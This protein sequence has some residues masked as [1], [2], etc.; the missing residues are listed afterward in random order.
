MRKHKHKRSVIG[1][2]VL[3]AVGSGLLFAGASTQAQERIE[4]T[5]SAIKR[6]DAEAALPV[7][8]ITKEEIVRSGATTT[9]DLL[10]RLPAIQNG[11]GESS[12]V[13]GG[14][15]FNGVS[16]HSIGDTRTL[17]LLN[18]RR[19]AQYGMQELTG[20][21]AGFDLN[22]VPLAAIERVEIL[23]D[24]ASALY[25][26]DAI[27]GVVNFITKRDTT[28]GDVSIGYSY[29]QGG[30]RETRISASKGFGSLAQDG[31]NVMLSVAHDERTKLD[32]VDRNF[33][34]TANV[35][36]NANG[37]NYRVQQITP[38]T[39]PGNVLDD[40]GQLIN[41]YLIANGECAPSSF[42]VTQPYDD[43]S[44]LV[45][46][47]CG[48][49]FVGELEIYPVRKRDT[50]MFSGNL[51]A[52]D[53]DL[54][55]DLLYAKNNQTS[56]IAP[57][58]GSISI[59]TTSPLFAQ[60]LAPL[61]I[62]QD[63]LAFYRLY[64]LGKRESDIHSKFYDLALGSRGMLAGWDYNASIS[65]SQSKVK[66]NIAGYPGALAVA[67]LRASGLLD[68]FV[69]IGQQSD[70]AN[71]AIAA[72]AYNGY[73]DGGDS[74]L[75]T[76]AL[77]GSREILK[78]P[79]GPMLLGVGLAYQREKFEK[80]PSPFAQGI[81]ADPVAGTLCDPAATSG[82]TQCD[83]RFGDEAA[84]EA[85]T[86]SRKS[87]G[88]FGELV[89]PATKELEFTGSV[90]YDH[91]SD[92]GNATT[93]KGSFRWQPSRQMLVRGSVGTGFHAPTV[94]Q[95]NA[96]LQ[97]FG[98]TNGQYSCTPELLT[99][100][101]GLGA[102]CQPG[103]KQY[104]QISGGN[105]GLKP[106]KSQQATLGLRF[107]PSPDVSLGADLW[108]VNIKNAFGQVTED[109]VFADPLAYSN[110]WTTKR[111]TGTGVLYLAFLAANQNLGNEYYTGLDLDLIGRMKLGSAN[112]TS[113]LMATYMIREE[114]QLLPD[115]PYY[116]SIGNHAELGQVTF[117]WRAKWSNTV[118]YGNWTHNVTANYQS[119]YV[120][121]PT[122]VEEVDA[123]GNVIGRENIR[124]NVREYI[125]F[126]W[127][128]SY[129]WNKALTLSVGAL[130]LF[131]DAPPLSISNGGNNRG[132]QFGFDDRYYDSR[133]RTWYVNASYTF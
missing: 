94:P 2:A 87:W 23:T 86:A 109:V 7:Q 106:E 16:I 18:G 40:Q 130:N 120:D 88:V 5:G 66:E 47:Y 30:A 35:F 20:F 93:F 28:A 85:Y 50:F 60:Y 25:G 59:P 19:L 133:G 111:D 3:A 110:A 37:K 32:A 51:R 9:T 36:F 79:A 131:D 132:Q 103:N 96:R 89:I 74:T 38:S 21:A 118:K 48:F 67:R 31:F 117:R 72:T 13:G 61:G 45:D 108:H 101:T 62:T 119:G 17:V 53:H 54:Y 127:Q 128:T 81:L 116:S 77:R 41:P 104:D 10:Q 11:F 78:M 33:G 65:R 100:A 26:A 58:P 29:P 129:V 75:D 55:A 27:A 70:A 90:R 125:T 24:G 34:N 64:D 6:I 15:G 82:P 12:A 52:G 123:A 99:I 69:G 44:G 56:R 113:Q 76:I 121:A 14:S 71:D 98:V 68:P 107:E 126:D 43:G 124:L 122:D 22:A 91:Y 49:D 105:T 102:N 92:F 57:V 73:W 39:I 63:T 46:D 115:G 42:R 1:Q 84:T 8:V 83:S 4:I 80:K 97:P 114:K 112:L 95:V